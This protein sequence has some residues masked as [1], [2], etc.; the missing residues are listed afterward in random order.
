MAMVSK[1]YSMKDLIYK[2]ALLNAVEYNGKANPKAVLGKVISE[3]PDLKK[4]ISKLMK[5]I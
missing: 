5:E 1:T 2:H 4:E 3:N